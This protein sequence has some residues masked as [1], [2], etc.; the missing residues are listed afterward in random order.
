MSRLAGIQLKL[1]R[2]QVHLDCLAP[3]VGWFY[4]DKLN[5]PGIRIDFDR[6]KEW[7]ELIWD[8][9][10]PMPADWGLMLGDFAHNARG[11]LDHLV[12]EMVVASKIAKPGTHTQFPI[13]KDEDDWNTRVVNPGHDRLPPTHGLRDDAFEMVKAFQPWHLTKFKMPTPDAKTGR[14][15][16]LLNTVWNTDKHRSVYAT[17]PY[18]FERPRNLKVLSTPSGY[19]RIGRIRYVPPTGEFI[20]NGTKLALVE[21]SIVREPP[22]ECG[23]YV[24]FQFQS[25]IVFAVDTTQLVRA[26]RLPPILESAR[27][28][29]SRAKTLGL[30]G[31]E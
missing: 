3:A 13:T 19:V 21:T 17:Y 20:K 14:D 10:K 11:A 23:V 4:K 22:E 31:I 16:R 18:S 30:P 24:E 26:E 1:D 7:Q 8:R 29:V 28:V 15:L 6:T 12:Y 5:R 2:A 9:I 25:N 27:K